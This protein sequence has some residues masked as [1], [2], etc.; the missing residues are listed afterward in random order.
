MV[1]VLSL[2]RYCVWPDAGAVHGGM[3]VAD[4]IRR[5]GVTGTP[6]QILRPLETIILSLALQSSLAVF[7]IQDGRIP[8]KQGKLACAWH[9]RV[10][11]TRAYKQHAFPN[12]AG[13]RKGGR[14][15]KEHNTTPSGWILPQDSLLQQGYPGGLTGE[16]TPA[17]CL[18]LVADLQRITAIPFVGE[19]DLLVFRQTCQDEVQMSQH[20]FNSK[21][22]LVFASPI[23]FHCIRS[24]REGFAVEI[25]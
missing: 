2:Y 23:L 8:T 14:Q 11:L 10:A 20:A 3:P 21:S 12:H 19:R 25:I 17:L 9:L 13:P 16:A 7:P 24:P 4:R 5:V 18:R 6:L 15:K 1:P 22:T